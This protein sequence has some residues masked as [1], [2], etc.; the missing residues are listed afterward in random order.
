MNH[1]IEATIRGL[2]PLLMHRYVEDGTKDPHRLPIE[3][4]AERGVYRNKK[5]FLYAPSTWLYQ[6]MV[7]AGRYS[8]GK[9]GASLMH[10]TAG[11]IVVTPDEIPL[12]TK[13]Y[14]IDAR[15]AVNKQMRQAARIMVY[16]P[17]L[18]EWTMQFSLLYN[19]DVLTHEQVRKILDDAGSMVG[20]GSYRPANKGPF[21]RFQVIGWERGSNG[22]GNTSP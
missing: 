14:E 3:E 12:G 13:T 6:A 10:A 18:D 21:G 5:G 8:K 20:L 9:R 19:S 1:Q 4:Q 7:N 11:A 15:S 2:S 22:N 16:R 17:R